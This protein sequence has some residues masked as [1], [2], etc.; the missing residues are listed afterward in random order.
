MRKIISNKR[1]SDWLNLKSW[2]P[3][4]IIFTLGFL[5]YGQTLWFGFTYFDDDVLVLDNAPILQNIKNIGAIFLNDVFFG[6][7]KLYYRPLLN[8]SLMF[9]AHIGGTS[10]FVY[11]LDNILLHII[12]TSLVFYLLFL[13]IK[14]K[15]LAFWL[16]VFFLVHPVISQAIAWIPGRNDSLLTI[17]V[18]SGFVFFLSFLERPRLLSYLAYLL[19]LFL[20]LLTK[21]TALVFPILVIFYLLFIDHKNSL[22]TDL[23]LL[24]FGSATVEFIWFLM[25]S[26]AMNNLTT[27][28]TIS[29]SSFIEKIPGIT[30]NIG[31][32][33]FPFNL[34]IF[35]T[36]MDSTLFYGISVLVI[37]A[38]ILILSKQK[39][40]NYIIFG[41]LWFFIFYFPSFILKS[42]PDFFINFLEHR[43][44]L[45]F[46]GFLIVIAEVDW[47]KNLNFNRRITQICG[48]T[49]LIV[50]AT[51]TFCHSRGFRN[52]L[53]FWQTAAMASP[54]S[55]EIQKNLGLEYYDIKDYNKAEYCYNLALALNSLEPKLHN[56]LGVLYMDQGK[57]NLAKKEFE[58]ELEI[59]FNNEQITQAAKNNLQ[60]LDNRQKL[61]E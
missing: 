26:L 55:V 58:K 8:I 14:R 19:F 51:I 17:F 35:P 31:K 37:L 45:S 18:L 2:R 27:I 12:A 4:S 52:S 29:L 24:I 1:L 10:P 60:I 48:I 56:N 53:V 23:F 9:D 40:N 47:I 33:L 54:H 43:L 46:F 57:Y 36:L 25:H 6:S 21:E 44:Y 32:L 41:C 49:L 22:K 38:I 15:I 28:N 3:Y 61:L 50:F 59:S 42:P 13:L 30:V 34:S 7:D 39:R 16:S 11:H 20:A 5:L